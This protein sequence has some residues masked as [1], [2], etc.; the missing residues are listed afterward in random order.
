MANVVLSSVQ[1]L[2]TSPVAVGTTVHVNALALN[3]GMVGTVSGLCHIVPDR[4]IGGTGIVW[5]N[6]S[7]VMGGTM[8]PLEMYWTMEN[9]TN[10]FKVKLQEKDA[11]GVWQDRFIFPTEFTITPIP[12]YVGTPHA[13][14]WTHSIF[15]TIIPTGPVIDI[16]VT[17]ENVGDSTGTMQA[18]VAEDN[19]NF[20]GIPPAFWK[21]IAPG[22]REQF[23]LRFTMPDY[24]VQFKLVAQRWDWDI[25][26]WINDDV[27]E[28]FT[29]TK[30][31]VGG[32]AHAVILSNYIVPSKAA[33][34]DTVAITFT[35]KN[36]GTGSGD[37]LMDT[38]PG[39]DGFINY[40]ISPAQVT[41]TANHTATF[42][43]AF[44]MP[45]HAVNFSVRASHV[46]E[47]PYQVI[48]DGT[49]GPFTIALDIGQATITILPTSGKVGDKVTV[50]GQD[51]KA[52]STITV[53]IGGVAL[54][55]ATS[56]ASGKFTLPDKAVPTLTAGVKTVSATD[57]TNTD[58]CSFTVVAD[59]G[60]TPT[61][62]W[63]K[64]MDWFNAGNNKWYVIGGGAA[65]VG[66]VLVVSMSGGKNPLPKRRNPRFMG[67][68]K[69]GEYFPFQAYAGLGGPTS[70]RAK[71]EP[72]PSKRVFCELGFHYL[73]REKAKELGPGTFACKECLGKAKSFMEKR[74]LAES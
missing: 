30:A 4:A 39:A 69:A 54:G 1:V 27:S 18:W 25:S 50:T 56:D 51:F 62:W 71:G 23:T 40:N 32:E 38:I 65:V 12:P 8:M 70:P 17:V 59:D 24:N 33:H 5:S 43:L 48:A 55:T 72:K 3:L 16:L 13:H 61:D 67:D 35:V 58:T 49:I 36:D 28:L 46:I 64:I 41:I 15:P 45:A 42:D 57:G 21:D 9:V 68:L 26:Q 7:L 53:T 34:G 19:V 44:T 63:K 10:T 37:I 60:T 20:E 66:L 74:R 6:S 31:A 11:S 14:I 73:P 29:I 22:G 52:S 2:E 47:S